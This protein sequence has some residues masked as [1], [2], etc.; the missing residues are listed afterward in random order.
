MYDYTPKEHD[1]ILKFKPWR[2]RL[3]DIVFGFH[4]AE[5][6]TFDLVNGYGQGSSNDLV[7]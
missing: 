1:N 4:T 3:H 5:G 7:T 2:K 6:K